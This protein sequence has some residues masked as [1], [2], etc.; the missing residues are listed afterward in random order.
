MAL[1]LDQ[2]KELYHFKISKMLIGEE[3][4]ETGKCSRWVRRKEQKQEKD[5]IYICVEVSYSGVEQKSLL[6][7]HFH[8]EDSERYFSNA[9]PPEDYLEHLISSGDKVSGGLLFSLYQDVQPSRL[10]FDT[11][12]FYEDSQDPVLIDIALPVENS[13]TRTQFLAKEQE[14]A[15]FYTQEIESDLLES[16]IAPKSGTES[17]IRKISDECR[18]PHRK[19]PN[20]YLLRISLPKGR[21]QNVVLNFAG[22]DEKGNDLVTIGTICAPSKNV[23]ND[24]ILLKLNPKIAYGGIGI[25]TIRGEDFY[26]LTQT[27]S[28]SMLH[29]IKI[30]QAVEAIAQK[31][32]WLEDKLTNGKDIR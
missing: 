29:H 23:K 13:E 16:R 25:S 12:I 6:F 10:W 30:S 19:I 21:K 26:V 27:Y 22:K 2:V 15:E 18:V 20:G 5:L 14:L 17:L 24:R 8:L 32:D 3:A 9:M 4:V 1:T 7:R 31:G 28:V 11:G